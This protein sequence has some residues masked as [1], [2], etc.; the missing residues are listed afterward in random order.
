MINKKQR[1][2]NK[3]KKYQRETDWTSFRKYCKATQKK[4][5]SEYWKYLAH[6][7][8]PEQDKEK[9]SFWHYIKSLNK[10]TTGISPLKDKGILH[11]D[12]KSKADILS[13][14]FQSVFTNENLTTL[15]P[16]PPQT[17]SSQMPPNPSHS[18]RH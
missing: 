12:S 3:A 1:L 18:E 14:Q 2:Y 5:Q 6:I 11:T 4:I 16:R 10:D 17:R 13:N 8:D 15:P 9:K 7:I